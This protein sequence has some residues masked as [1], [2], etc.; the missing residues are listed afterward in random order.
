MTLA[1][2][3]SPQLQVVQ[4]EAWFL[5]LANIDAAIA[6][7]NAVGKEADGVMSDRLEAIGLPRLPDVELEVVEKSN[8]HS[9]HRPSL[10]QAPI[11]QYPNI[12]VMADRADPNPESAEFDHLSIF[13][14]RLRVE[15]MV[16]ADSEDMIESRI[17]RMTAAV[18]AIVMGNR[19]LS[20]TV[21]EIGDT[22][23]VF[24]TDVFPRQE[25]TSYG[26]QWYWQGARIDYGVVKEATLQMSTNGAFLRGA[27][28]IDQS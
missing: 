19:T 17:H 22:P 27:Y 28:D 12:S 18:N 26:A 16:K 21:Q 15:V 23:R 5:I 2:N 9:G 10:I 13:T 24:L 7:Y 20:G 14:D 25:Q 4:R 8:I 3:G 11:D 6:E 1:I